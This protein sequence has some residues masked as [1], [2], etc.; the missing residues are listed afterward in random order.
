MDY[1][2]LVGIHHCSASADDDFLTNSPD[3]SAGVFAVNC[4]SGMYHHVSVLLILL[5]TV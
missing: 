4:S 1:S 3:A 2:L 5:F